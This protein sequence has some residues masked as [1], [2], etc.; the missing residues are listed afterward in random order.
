MK[1]VLLI[2][3]ILNYYKHKKRLS[4]QSELLVGHKPETKF[5]VNKQVQR[6]KYLP[7]IHISLPLS[8]VA[9]FS[10]CLRVS[11]FRLGIKIFLVEPAP[12]RQHYHPQHQIKCDGRK[13]TDYLSRNIE[14]QLLN[15]SLQISKAAL[16][17]IS[18]LILSAWKVKRIAHSNAYGWHTGRVVPLS[19][20]V[21]STWSNC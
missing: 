17:N 10:L 15:G 6:Y 7:G 8:V 16:V 4:T 12:F 14:E 19:S 11:S 1:S 13:D 18:A 2:L 3:S 20:T 21:F 5:H 9:N